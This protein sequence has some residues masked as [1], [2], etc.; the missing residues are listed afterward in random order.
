MFTTWYVCV[1]V[2]SEKITL[3]TSSISVAMVSRVMMNIYKK[4]DVDAAEFNLPILREGASID[5]PD[6][7]SPEAEAVP[8]PDPCQSV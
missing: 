2:W 1:L 5:V 6:S 8:H 7:D 3:R 4:T